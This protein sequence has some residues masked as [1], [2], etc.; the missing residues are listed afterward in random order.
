MRVAHF[1]ADEVRRRI[2]VAV[3]KA[4]TEEVR[5]KISKK[6]L[7][8]K[9]TQ[10]HKDKLSS[11]GRNRPRAIVCKRG[12]PYDEINTYVSSRGHRCCLTCYYLG[13]KFNLPTRLQK[14]ET[15]EEIFI[16]KSSV[17]EV[18]I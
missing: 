3:S 1:F 14:Y 11:A 18:N 10:D 4:M 17:K 13:K 8:K 9:F 7:G 2:S 6:Q 15:G 16:K 5:E 12:H